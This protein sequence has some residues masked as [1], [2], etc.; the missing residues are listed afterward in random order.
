[1]TVLTTR[2]IGSD[3]SHTV[4]LETPIGGAGEPRRMPRLADNW[5]AIPRA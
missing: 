3:A 1:M 5:S 2:R 4:R